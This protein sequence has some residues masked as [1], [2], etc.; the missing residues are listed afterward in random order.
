[1]TR[2]IQLSKSDKF[3]H[4]CDFICIFLKI[5]IKILV[6]SKKSKLIHLKL[7]KYETATK[8]FLKI[9]HQNMKLLY[10]N[11]NYSKIICITTRKLVLG[12]RKIGS[13]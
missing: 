6:R 4:L 5:K 8:M 11:L 1:M 12:A 10:T 3:G 7:E 13:R 9:T 2:V